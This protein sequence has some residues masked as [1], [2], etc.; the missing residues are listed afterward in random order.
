M[1]NTLSLSI[2]NRIDV[3][4][5]HA[6]EHKP[7]SVRE[8][9]TSVKTGETRGKL[10]VGTILHGRLYFGEGRIYG[11]FTEA[12]TPKGD[13]YKVCMQFV[14]GEN[15]VKSGGGG[16]EKPGPGAPMEPGST[17]DNALIFSIQYVGAVER[18][19]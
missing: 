15:V 4:L 10:P 3:Y 16:Y 2:G 5:P 9:F 12:Q 8:G 6:G 1:T 13:T 14:T 18:F 7:V 11:R 17:P 19:E